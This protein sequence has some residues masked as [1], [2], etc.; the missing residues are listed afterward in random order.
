M[1]LLPLP[2]D[3]GKNG[4]YAPVAGPVSGGVALDAEGLEGGSAEAD[5]LGLGVAVLPEGTALALG[6]GL[7]VGL[8]LAVGDLTHRLE[9]DFSPRALAG[10]QPTGVMATSTTP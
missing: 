2:L 1:K 10:P 4:G 9:I 7:D 6:L 5:G 8:N 3:G